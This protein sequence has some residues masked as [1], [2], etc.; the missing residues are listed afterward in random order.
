MSA[1]VDDDAQDLQDVMSC[2][3]RHH[4]DITPRHKSKRS[5][6][7]DEHDY[8]GS[9]SSAIKINATHIQTD[10]ISPHSERLASSHTLSH[11]PFPEEKLA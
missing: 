3:R 6:P 10:G 2:H 9:Y 1:E 11:D 5:P 7:Q 8:D 4:T